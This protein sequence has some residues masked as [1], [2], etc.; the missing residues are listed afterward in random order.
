MNKKVISILIAILVAGAF[1]VLTLNSSSAFNFLP[2]LIH[3]AI[4]SNG[5]GETEFIV[6]FDIVVAFLLFWA[7]YMISIRTIKKRS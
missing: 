7:V 3:G 2:Y 5:T 6:I 1:L 4:S